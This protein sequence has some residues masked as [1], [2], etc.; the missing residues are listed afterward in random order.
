MVESTWAED[1]GQFLCYLDPDT[2][3]LE[4]KQCPIVFNGTCLNI[5]L[6]PKCILFKCWLSLNHFV[7]FVANQVQYNMESA[8]YLG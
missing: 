6:L 4:K 7:V 3:C 2:R 5:N 8:Q 1:M